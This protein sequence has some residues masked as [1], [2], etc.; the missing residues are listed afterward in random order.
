MP[1]HALERA[2]DALLV[3]SRRIVGDPD[4]GPGLGG[5]LRIDGDVLAPIVTS[6]ERDVILGPQLLD[7]LDP[8]D[9]ALH[10]VAALQAVELAFDAPTLLRHDAGADHQYG[11]AFG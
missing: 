11:T 5:W 8:L 4:R 7:Q 9:H 10:A 3:A 1:H 6:L 2:A